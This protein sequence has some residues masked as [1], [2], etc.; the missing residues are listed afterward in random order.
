MAEL[1]FLERRL[2]G[3]GNWTHV[4]GACTVNTLPT[5]PS[6]QPSTVIFSKAEIFPACLP[7]FLPLLPPF[8]FLFLPFPLIGLYVYLLAISHNHSVCPISHLPPSTYLFSFPGVLI[9]PPFVAVLNLATPKTTQNPDFREWQQQHH[10]LSLMERAN[11]L[12]SHACL[13][14][15]TPK[16]TNDLPLP[17][18]EILSS[19]LL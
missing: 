9:L 7:P 5:E 6:L 13:P 2:T 12:V 14:L 10:F 4:Q 3:P 11:P 17:L 15:P 1:G 18:P 16:T 8:L 19:L